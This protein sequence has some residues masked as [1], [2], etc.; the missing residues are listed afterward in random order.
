MTE[1]QLKFISD[2]VEIIQKGITGKVISPD[3]KIQV[4]K[5]G[6]IIRVD[7]KEVAVD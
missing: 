3:K 2:A 1:Q 7:I 4:Y 6:T 5:C